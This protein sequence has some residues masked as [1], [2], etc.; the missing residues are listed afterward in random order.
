MEGVDLGGTEPVLRRASDDQ[1]FCALAFKIMTDPY[2]GHLTYI[3][4]YSGVLKQ[5]MSVYNS[6]KKTRE[7]IGRLSADA[8]EQARRN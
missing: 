5:G 1:P 6:S 7:R 8:C 2:V 4:V 3:R